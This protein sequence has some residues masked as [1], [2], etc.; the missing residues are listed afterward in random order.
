MWP[1]RPWLPRRA[2]GGVGLAGERVRHRV[3][4]VAAGQGQLHGFQQ[5]QVVVHGAGAVV[6]DHG[7]LQAA[8]RGVIVHV[9]GVDQVLHAR[10]AGFQ[11][12]PRHGALVEVEQERRALA[13][14]R[15]SPPL[16]PAVSPGVPRCRRT[17]GL[18]SRM[19][20]ISSITSS[21]A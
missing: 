6:A 21:M 9:A 10:L 13:A 12:H 1:G 15:S 16:Y 19:G 8:D 17:L 2:V 14:R 7:V 4:V 5:V 11:H 18:G 20:V 3:Q